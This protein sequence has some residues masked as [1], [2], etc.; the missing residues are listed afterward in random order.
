MTGIRSIVPMALASA[1]ALPALFV[2]GDS[3]TAAADH[4][5]PPARVQ[6]GNANPP[7]IA[8]DLADLYLF[9]TA[10]GIVISS[11]FAGPRPNSEPANYS[12]DIHHQI[13][14]SN[15]G[16][17]TDPEI[18]IEFRFGQDPANPKAFG[19][20]ITGLPGNGTLV[21]PCETVFTTPNGIKIKVGL[22]DD[23][24]NFDPQGLTETRQTGR[25][26][27]RSDRNRF[28][29]ENSTGIVFE[30]PDALIRNGTHT[31]DT[32]GTSLRFPGTL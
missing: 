19:V 31:I 18:T 14:I 30:F 28:A 22:F 27:I 20:Q 6:V 7:D 24:F 16:A 15:A 21:I 17:R 13:F 3:P 8:A 2:A 10:T 9:P 4:F 32:W 1:L 23:P 11:D 25:L 5:D 26:S 12:R 29:N